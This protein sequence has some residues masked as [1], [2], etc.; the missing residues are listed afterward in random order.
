[1]TNPEENF[2]FKRIMLVVI[3]GTAYGQLAGAFYREQQFVPH[4][5]REPIATIMGTSFAGS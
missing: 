2:L 1:M 3:L 5:R 4:D